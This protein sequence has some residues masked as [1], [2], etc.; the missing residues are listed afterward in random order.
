MGK[1]LSGLGQGIDIFNEWTGRIVAYT[2]LGLT[3]VTLYNVIARYIFARPP[4][5]A[6]DVNTYLF[7]MLVFLGAGYHVLHR[8]YITVDVIYNRMPPRIKAVASLF[9]FIMAC[10]FCYVV[11]AEG[12]EMALRSISRLERISSAWKPIAYPLR[13]LVPIGGL[14]IF[15]QYTRNFISDFSV[16]IRGKEVDERDS[17]PMDE[18]GIE[19]KAD[20]LTS[21]PGEE[22]SSGN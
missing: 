20:E 9:A 22:N 13:A 18:M 21:E 19:I 14:L 11:I 4:I 2:A 3:F 5:W 10:I 15:V 1:I 12:T 7:G 6:W 17:F 8:Q 16:L